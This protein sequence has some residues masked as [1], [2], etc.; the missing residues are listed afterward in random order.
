ERKDFEE[1]VI[2]YLAAAQAEH[3][4]QPTAAKIKTLLMDAY[5]EQDLHID[6]VQRMIDAALGD[7]NR[8][9]Q[10]MSKAMQRQIREVEATALY[11]Q[12]SRGGHKVR[13]AELTSK[14]RER[15]PGLAG[16]F[17]G[18]VRK[19]MKAWHGQGK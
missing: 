14:L 13:P 9:F 3:R 10:K 4:P 5:D 18:T 6:T 11:A 8:T 17:D 16:T 1:L 2:G 7:R 12:L 19:W 15:Y